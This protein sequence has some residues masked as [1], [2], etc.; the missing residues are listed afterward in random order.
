MSAENS[1]LRCEVEST[2]KKLSSSQAK[3]NQLLETHQRS[4]E[5]ARSARKAAYATEAALQVKDKM[6]TVKEEEENTVLQLALAKAEEKA[7][8]I[9][10]LIT[11]SYY[12][13]IYHLNML[14]QLSHRISTIVE[15]PQNRRRLIGPLQY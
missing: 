4:L 11:W 1:K 12:Y 15:L 6:I 13:Y 14:S 9:N 2:K 3:Y 10:V 7:K 5:L 8:V